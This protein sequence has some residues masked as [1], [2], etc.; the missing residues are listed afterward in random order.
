MPR[1]GAQALLC[2]PEPRPGEGDPQSNKSG[3]NLQIP[4]AHYH[5]Q[6]SEKSC[7]RKPAHSRL[8][9]PPSAHDPQEAAG[10]RGWLHHHP[11]HEEHRHTGARPQG[12]GHHMTLNHSRGS[13]NRLPHRRGWGLAL[14][15]GYWQ[16][17]PAAEPSSR[18]S[19]TDSQGMERIKGGGQS[20]ESGP[21]CPGS[22][23]TFRSVQ[24]LS[25]VRLFSTP[26]TAARQA[27]LSITNS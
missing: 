19:L 9:G 8:A 16:G 13:S 6:G 2:Q 20:L 17:C 11:S 3:L 12:L 27:S 22:A 14:G 10:N 15:F 5:V 7:I 25:C 18:H 21:Q 23:E 1:C 24:S 4:G 26:W